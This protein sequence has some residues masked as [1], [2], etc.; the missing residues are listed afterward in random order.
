MYQIN[1]H[2]ASNI[3]ELQN[4]VQG[5]Y[6]KIY[7]DKGASLQELSLSGKDI[8]VDLNPLTY[9]DTYASSILFPFA[10]RIKDGKYEFNGESYQLETNQKEEQNALH[11]LVYNKTFEVMDTKANADGVSVSLKYIET[12]KSKGFPFTFEIDVEYAFTGNSL[13]L[14]ISVKNTDSKTFPFTLGWHPYF[15]SN[16]LAE[17]NL[18]FESDEKFVLG[19]R[20]ITIGT[21]SFSL[22]GSFK[23]ENKKLDDC[24]KLDSNT[25]Q[26]NTPNYKFVIESTDYNNF[27]QVYTPPKY[28]I[29][30]IEP[31]TGISDSFNNGIGLKTLK[32][33]ET[34]KI[35]WTLKMIDNQII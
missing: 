14:G 19:N 32:P 30:A 27:L 17:S 1:H 26:F 3:L 16:N 29:I 9:S 22:F 20:N 35:E 18:L 13:K 12:S 21:E 2:K 11:G 5:F 15:V 23:I 31:T 24:W 10:N 28:N 25:I 33:S 4:E 8:I 7:L 6:A 34:Y